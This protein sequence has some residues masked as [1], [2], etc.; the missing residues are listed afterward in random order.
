VYDQASLEN[1]GDAAPA[2]VMV[3]FVGLIAVTMLARANR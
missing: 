3:S 2:A 1:L